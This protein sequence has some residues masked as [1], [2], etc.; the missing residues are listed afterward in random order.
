M[1]TQISPCPGDISDNSDKA[2]ED[3]RKPYTEGANQVIS[4][5]MYL[6]GCGVIREL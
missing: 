5:E 3:M 4:C 6:S 2:K 1:G